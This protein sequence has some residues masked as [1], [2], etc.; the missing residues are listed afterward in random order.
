MH[1]LCPALLDAV[2]SLRCNMFHV[3]QFGKVREGGGHVI[4]LRPKQG[5]REAL[6]SRGCSAFPALLWK[7]WTGQ[8]GVRAAKGGQSVRCVAGRA[9]AARSF[10]VERFGPCRGLA[11]LILSGVLCGMPWNASTG[12]GGELRQRRRGGVWE[13]VLPI[14]RHNE[15]R[16]SAINGGAS[17]LNA[18]RAGAERAGVQK[19]LQG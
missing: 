4:G 19:Y 1:G 7:V 12:Q 8:G 16:Y 6:Q 18:G 17:R 9:G 10:F 13:A 11:G 14:I 15:R 2:V 3:E 5:R